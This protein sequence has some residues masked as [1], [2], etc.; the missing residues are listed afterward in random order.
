VGR[1][2]GSYEG[3]WPEYITPRPEGRGF[4]R[5][6]ANKMPLY[7]VW[8]ATKQ[9]K[10]LLQGDIQDEA[11]TQFDAIALRYSI[12][13]LER[14][15]IVD[16]VHMLLNLPDKA[17]LSKAM[18]LLKGASSRALFQKYPSIKMDAHTNAF[19]QVGFGS[20]IIP[21]AREAQVR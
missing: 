16:H 1:R 5:K 15:A 2:W 12:V 4:A 8:F 14:E 3:G 21:R 10:W 20:K 6:E 13:L 18:N 7:H 11:K 19:W 17:G 9:R